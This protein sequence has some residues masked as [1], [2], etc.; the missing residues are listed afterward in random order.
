M[1]S[2]VSGKIH[3]QFWLNNNSFEEEFKK[4]LD[5]TTRLETEM[6]VLKIF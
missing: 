3:E 5:W 2:P 1:L 4:E 6:V